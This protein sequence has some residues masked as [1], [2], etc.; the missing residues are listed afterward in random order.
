MKETPIQE[1]ARV[2]L[3]SRLCP[4]FPLLRVTLL[5]GEE[6]LLGLTPEVVAALRKALG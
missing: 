3:A 1:V 5:S 4:G 6:I 2:T